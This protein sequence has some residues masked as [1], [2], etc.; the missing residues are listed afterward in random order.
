M[1]PYNYTVIFK[2]YDETVL[3]STTYHYGDTVVVPATPVKPADNTYTYTFNGWDKEVI[4]CNG[5]ATY[6]ATYSSVYIDYTVQFKNDDGTI[7]SSNTYHYGDT[8]IVPENPVKSADKI[9]TYSF[10]G[11]DK[12]ISET[13][14]GDAEYTATYTQSKIEDVVPSQNGGSGCS[15]NVSA[16]DSAGNIIM[17]IGAMSICFMVV[18]IRKKKRYNV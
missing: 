5:N 16:G 15:G 11:W 8:V 2:N 4:N 7:L 10:N 12:E 6:T 3:K 14:I 17:S 13:C 18:I 9:Y 1:T